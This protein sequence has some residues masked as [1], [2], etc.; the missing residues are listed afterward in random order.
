MDESPPDSSSNQVGGGGDTTASTGAA[1][2]GAAGKIKTDRNEQY[3]LRVKSEFVLACRAASLPVLQSEEQRGEPGD[4]GD[5]RNGRGSSSSSG[6]QQ[7]QQQQRG[8]GKKRGG[9]NRS[10]N[11]K[12]PRDARI[13]SD[14][15]LCSYVLR[16]EPCPYYKNEQEQVD[17]ATAEAE[18]GPPPAKKKPDGGGDGGGG[19]KKGKGKKGGGNGSGGSGCRFLHDVS[20]FLKIRPPDI[21]CEA[22]TECPFYSKFGFCRFGPACRFGAVHLHQHQQQRDADGATATAAGD[23]VVVPPKP[24]SEPEAIKN[25][26][27]RELQD[28]L[29][30][31]R[32][33]FKCQRHD[34]KGRHDNNNNNNNNKAVAQPPVTSS[35]TTTT[36]PKDD[37]SKPTSSTE[38]VAGPT[39]VVDNGTRNASTPASATTTQLPPSSPSSFQPL[40]TKERKLIDFSNKVYVAPLTTVGNLPFRRVMKRY[41]ADI[42]CGEMAMCSKLVEGGPSEWALLKRHPSEDV[43]GVQLAAGYPDLFTRTAELIDAHTEVDFVDLNLGCPLDIVCQKGAGS[44]L[45]LRERRLRD[46]LRGIA[47]ALRGC[48]ITIKMRTGWDE[49]KPFAHSLVPKIVNN[50]WDLPPN[51]IGAVMIH[52]RSR[53]QRYSRDADWDYIGQVA[54]RA[55]KLHEEHPQQQP[56]VPIIGNGD[57]FSYTDYEQKVLSRPELSTCAMLGRGALIKPWLPTEIKERRHW[58][59]SASERFDILK[60]YVNFGLEH[61][62][63]D[64][65]GVNNCRR[66]LLEWL[67]FLYRYV[68]VGLL[69]VLPQQMNHRPPM[70]MQGR[71]DLE[72]LFLSPESSDWVKISEMLLGPVEPGFRFEPKHKANS[73]RQIEG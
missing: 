70:H 30:K 53:L 28:Q 35:T 2:A 42:T 16:G 15:K 22:K 37:E 20:A 47:D 44:S 68:P 7:Q 40:P 23:H 14:A 21:Q 45:M 62:G 19:N 39:S 4:D 72:T 43:F 41:G 34:S 59:I 33:P 31:R 8:G 67:S 52:G 49:A 61:W 73:Y 36:A 3:S 60:D 71:N 58:D 46:S 26:L 18:E 57:I 5:D 65:Q 27:T 64:Q 69:E 11:K 29:R 63:S 66:F 25:I 51:S 24:A 6:K 54:A 9:T 48:P 38:A 10:Q 1:A 32:Y 55:A 12:R 56:V 17:K 13:A 50:A